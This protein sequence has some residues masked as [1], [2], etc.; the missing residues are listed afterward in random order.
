MH[1]SYEPCNLCKIYSWYAAV[2]SMIRDV[3]QKA[4][5]LHQGSQSST[6]TISNTSVKK[7]RNASPWRRDATLCK[8][9]YRPL[10][11]VMYPFKKGVSVVRFHD[12]VMLFPSTK[13]SCPLPRQLA[14]SFTSNM[15]IGID[16]RRRLLPTKVGHTNL[17]LQLR[18]LDRY[19]CPLPR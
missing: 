4:A 16:I 3:Y 2:L 6:R 12:Q 13:S 17:Y 15:S 7:C 1:S 5:E 9:R 10:F 11:K 8:Q 18:Y 14:T 19:L